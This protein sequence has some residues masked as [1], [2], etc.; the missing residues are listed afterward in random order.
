MVSS[1]LT[2]ANN[3]SFKTGIVHTMFKEVHGPFS[4]LLH[5]T[6]DFYPLGTSNHLNF[7]LKVK[8]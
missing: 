5:S 6:G 3:L 8:L 7:P 1:S 2:V 4:V